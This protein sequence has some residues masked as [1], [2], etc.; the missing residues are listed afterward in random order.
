MQ[1]N[2]PW[3]FSVN[4]AQYYINKN[5]KI[6]AGL[7]YSENTQVKVL[8]FLVWWNNIAIHIKSSID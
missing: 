7:G 8:D 6:N 1:F 5:V 3:I 2:N 4:F